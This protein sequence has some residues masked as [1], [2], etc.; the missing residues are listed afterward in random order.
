MMPTTRIPAAL[1]RRMPFGELLMDLVV[2]LATGGAGWMP[3]PMPC[4][5]CRHDTQVLKRTGPARYVCL[6]CAPKE[7]SR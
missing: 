1:T 3:Y 7:A 4:A 5:S 6:S 2:G